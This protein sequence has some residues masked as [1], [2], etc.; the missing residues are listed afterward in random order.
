MMDA[1][2]HN[3]YFFMLLTVTAFSIGSLIQKKTRIA[4]FNPLLIGAILVVVVL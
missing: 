3:G 4:L 2:L 1:L